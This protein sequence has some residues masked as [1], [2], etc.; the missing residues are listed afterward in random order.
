MVE[1][2]EEYVPPCVI[3]VLFHP[4]ERLFLELAVALTEPIA[5]FPVCLLFG[6]R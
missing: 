2:E 3:K 6:C 1:L 4:L 5:V